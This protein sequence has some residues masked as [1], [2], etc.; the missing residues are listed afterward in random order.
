MKN[1]RESGTPAQL[2][3]R[4]GAMFAAGALLVSTITAANAEQ[5]VSAGQGPYPPQS[6]YTDQVFWWTADEALKIFSDGGPYTSKD[7]TTL[8]DGS[9][10]VVECGINNLDGF[11]VSKIPTNTQ[12][13]GWSGDGLAW[14]Y[15]SGTTGDGNTLVNGLMT[16][17][18]NATPLRDILKDNLDKYWQ[19]AYDNQAYETPENPY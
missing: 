3:R 1:R 15:S 2:P 18:E 19:Y 7:E 13:G 12:A 16:G 9:K 14:M 5:S 11:L 17:R 4:L 6:K 10:L 8:P